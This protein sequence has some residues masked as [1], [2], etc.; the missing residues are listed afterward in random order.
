MSVLAGYVVLGSIAGSQDADQVGPSIYNQVIADAQASLQRKV[1]DLNSSCYELGSC[2][3]IV[4]DI[5]V[6]RLNSLLG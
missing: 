3:G 4:D 5:A 2:P 1:S 6:P